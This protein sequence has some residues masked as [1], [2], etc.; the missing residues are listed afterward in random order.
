MS[1][2]IFLFYSFNQISSAYAECVVKDERVCHHDGVGHIESE[3]A[4]KT[5]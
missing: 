2:Y 3:V 1:D 4:T 5:Y